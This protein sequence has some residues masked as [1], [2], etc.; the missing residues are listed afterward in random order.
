M[1]T[2]K[3]IRGLGRV[4][5]NYKTST[6]VEGVT[7]FCPYYVK[8]KGMFDRCYSGASQAYADCSVDPRW[9]SLKAFKSWM[10]KQDW[11]SLTILDKDLIVVGNKV[12]GPDTCMF[13]DTAI[14]NVL[15]KRRQGKYIRGVSKLGDAYATW[16]HERGK[17]RTVSYHKTELEAHL[18][19]IENKREN[20]LDLAMDM[21]YSTQI[22]QALTRHADLLK[23]NY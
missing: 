20:I 3:L 13:V 21:R 8:W 19:F 6:T 4:D 12:Y 18:K 15:V 11:E 22:R 5:V 23:T 7:T 1:I 2:T 17:K 9:Y 14:N 10:E 16:R